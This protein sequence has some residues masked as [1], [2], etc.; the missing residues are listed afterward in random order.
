MSI[1]IPDDLYEELLGASRESMRPIATEAVFWM[2]TGLRGG[3]S[4]GG[5]LP[6]GGTI[7]EPKKEEV[8]VDEGWLYDELIGKIGGSMDRDVSYD[9]RAELNKAVKDLGLVWNV[10]LKR[11]E[12][13]EDGKVKII[14]QFS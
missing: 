4:K 6:H 10:Y 14:H 12:K 9:E 8:K 1:T 3:I 5:F 7:P 13:F 11:L 2:K